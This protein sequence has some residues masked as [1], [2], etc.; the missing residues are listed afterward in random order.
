MA[1]LQ[2]LLLLA[3]TFFSAPPP[4]LA[5]FAP[6]QAVQAQ[7][8]ELDSDGDGWVSRR[9]ARRHREI[10]KFFEE[11]DSNKDGRLDEDEFIKAKAIAQRTAAVQFA[12]DTVLTA[13]VRARLIEKD[14][15][16][17]TAIHVHTRRGQVQLTGAVQT[18]DQSTLA[19]QAAAGVH[20]VSS[21]R[22]NLL[23]V[24]R[25]PAR[26]RGRSLST[27]APKPAE[28]SSES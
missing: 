16:P 10:L 15:L 18:Q 21:V 27:K 25:E 4:G 9:E 19:A 1:D 8:N 23:V 3:M 7:F 28:R 11:A 5:Q 26:E 20:G 6:G 22:N 12:E 2:S 17:S 24:G 14:G 13:R